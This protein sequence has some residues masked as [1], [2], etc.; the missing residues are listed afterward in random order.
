MARLFGEDTRI[1]RIDRG[2]RIDEM[3]L[4]RIRLLRKADLD[5]IDFVLIDAR[6]L[7][8]LPRQ[9][10][11]DATDSGNADVLAGKIARPLDAAPCGGKHTPREPSRIEDRPGDGDK[12]ETLFIR[13]KK[14]RRRRRAK[15]RRTGDQSGRDQQSVGREGQVQIEPAKK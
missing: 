5:P 10:V 12:I 9:H 14:H 2:H 7:H 6:R 11:D 15:R 3:P 1:E 8:P 13:L 4:E